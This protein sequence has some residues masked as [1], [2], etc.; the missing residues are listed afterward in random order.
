MAREKRGG[1]RK[2]KLGTVS[3]MKEQSKRDAENF[4]CKSRYEAL[5][6]VSIKFLHI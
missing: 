4:K 5:K 2:E 6:Q 3:V 1:A